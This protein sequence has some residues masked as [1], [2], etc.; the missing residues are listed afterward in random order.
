MEL[1][2]LPNKNENARKMLLRQQS[3]TKRRDTA[4]H[5]KHVLAGETFSP[6]DMVLPKVMHPMYVSMAILGL[7]WTSKEK[8]FRGVRCSFDLYTLHCCITLLLAWFWAFKY[9]AFYGDEVKFGM[10]LFQKLGPHMYAIQMACGLTMHVIYKQRHIPALFKLWENYK[11]KYGGITLSFMK[12]QVFF[13]VTLVNIG[14]LILFSSVSI[15]YVI[16]PPLSIAPTLYYTLKDAPL[17]FKRCVLIVILVIH[18]YLSLAW[19]QTVIFMTC[20]NFL[21]REEFN[22]ITR[23]MSGAICAEK[24]YTHQ[25]AITKPFHEQS[26]GECHVKHNLVEDY[27]QRHYDMCRLVGRYD[28]AVSAY[29]FFLYLFS[30]PI[31]VIGV[32]SFLGLEKGYVYESGL[33]FFFYVTTLAFFVIILFTVTISASRLAAAVSTLHFILSV[34]YKIGICWAKSKFGYDHIFQDFS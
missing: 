34:E 27:R 12:R 26:N 25:S 32:Y 8:W 2:K 33:M 10:W 21:M 13:R 23:E 9:F 30:V 11:L 31:I 17:D 6:E 1:E 14:L 15:L 24:S 20:T 28:D 4:T 29:L 16:K 5:V 3:S 22:E 18:I 7:L 19:L